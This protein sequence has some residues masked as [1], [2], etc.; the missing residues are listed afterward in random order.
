[1]I[2][3]LCKEQKI[4]L[5][6]YCIMWEVYRSVQQ[7]YLV[8]CIVCENHISGVVHEVHFRVCVKKNYRRKKPTCF[9]KPP[10]W[11]TFWESSHGSWPLFISWVHHFLRDL[12]WL[13]PVLRQVFV[14]VFYHTCIIQLWNHKQQKLQFFSISDLIT[15]KPKKKKN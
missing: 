15:Q 1:M 13:V 3:V 6:L 5:K 10:H 14:I 4:S 12:L 11:P 7:T 8:N 2:L 9:L